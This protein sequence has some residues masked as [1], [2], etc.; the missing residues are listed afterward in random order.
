MSEVPLYRL[1][2]MSE[3]PLCR[4]L[5]NDGYF[6][7]GLNFTWTLNLGSRTL[8]QSFNYAGKVVERAPVKLTGLTVN[9]PSS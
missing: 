1:F 3:V 7:A 8:S 4:Y 9:Y 6:Y 2:L 5:S